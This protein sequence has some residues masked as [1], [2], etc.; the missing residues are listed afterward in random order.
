MR[1]YAPPG[2]PISPDPD[3]YFALGRA[4]RE[5]RETAGMTQVAAGEAVGLRSQFISEVERGTRGVKWHTLLGLLR[6]YGADLHNLA[7][8]F[9]GSRSASSS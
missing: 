8:A 6:A 2:V 3:D 9:D 4:L 1:R 7:N 5:L